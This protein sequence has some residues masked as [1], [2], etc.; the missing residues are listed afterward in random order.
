MLEFA[1]SFYENYTIFFY[2][3]AII[4]VILEW[5][6]TVLAISSFLA[7]KYGISFFWIFLLAFIWDFFWD[8]LH[9]YIWR[10][11]K[12]IHSKIEKNKN[13]WK[14]IQKIDNYSIT[15]K[16]ILIK[17]TPP[18]TSIWLI[19]LWATKMKLKNFLKIDI[20]FCL[21]SSFVVSIIWY[22]LW[23]WLQNETNISKIIFIVWIWI[24][25]TYFIFKISFKIITK[26]I[27]DKNNPKT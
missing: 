11:W 9:F 4:A 23:K 21:I 1:I 8:L 19:Y 10:F 18:I 3:L 17:Y 7:P 5:P 6:L 22:F 20:L 13:F 24:I 27:E 14:I 16:I 12:N 2:I 25:F 26:K 15:D